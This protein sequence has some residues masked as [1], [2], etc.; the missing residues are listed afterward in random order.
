MT[1]INVMRSRPLHKVILREYFS[2]GRGLVFCLPQHFPCFWGKTREKGRTKSTT[3]IGRVFF[4]PKNAPRLWAEICLKLGGRF[5][6]FY[7]FFCSGKGEGESE[8][9]GGGGVD[10]LLKIPGGGSPG[11]EGEGP[12]GWEG[13]CGELGHW[14]RGAKYFFSGPKCPPRKGRLKTR[15]WPLVIYAIISA[16]GLY[17][18]C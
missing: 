7:F 12:R 15:P 17:V 2:C 16:G 9:S 1:E 4:S 10:F 5:G 18:E 11:E 14:G 13:V 8:A 6:Y 3:N